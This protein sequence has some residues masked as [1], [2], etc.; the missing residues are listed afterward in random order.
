ML[1]FYPALISFVETRKS[2][3]LVASINFSNAVLN[4]QSWKAKNWEKRSII[5]DFKCPS[6]FSS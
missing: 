4:Y 3:E 5:L 2:I 6:E 1:I